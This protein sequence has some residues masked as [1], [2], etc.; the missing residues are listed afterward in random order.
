MEKIYL[1]LKL[2]CLLPTEV[3]KVA[4]IMF[5]CQKDGYV[6]YSPA[7]VKSMHM[8]R[9]AVEIAIQTLIDREIID[10]PVKEEKFW[11]F[12]INEANIKRYND[13]SWD[14]INNAPV[15]RMS[16]ETKFTHEPPAIQSY[17]HMSPEEMMKR[18]QELQAMILAQSKMKNNSDSSLPY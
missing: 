16:S 4:D 18:M 7:S 6:T 1:N 17:V 3:S 15:L 10:S 12:K 11:K 5:A 14:D 13:S 9:E 2:K 8:P